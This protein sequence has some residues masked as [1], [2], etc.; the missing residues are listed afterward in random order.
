M[1]IIKVQMMITNQLLLMIN[2]KINQ[3]KLKKWMIII[4]N[5]K[6]HIQHYLKD[7]VLINNKIKMK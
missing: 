3:N 2:L 5:L 7:I 4:K 1:M 6:K